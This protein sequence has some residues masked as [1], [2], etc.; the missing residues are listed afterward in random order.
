M[1][2]RPA[3]GGTHVGRGAASALAIIGVASVA[4]IAPSAALAKAQP[5]A[6]YAEFSHCPVYVKKVSACIVAQTTSGEFKLGKKTV[7]ITKT[8]TLQGGLKEGSAELIAPVGAEILSKVPIEVPG[9]L[10]GL[11]G[12]GLGGTTEVNATTELA[13]PVEV[14]QGNL[15][16]G[17]G[18]A[19]T[20]PV[21]VKLE[22]S[23]L[24]TECYVDSATEPIVMNLTTGTTKPPSGVTPITGSSGTINL[25]PTTS[26]ATLTGQS[27]VENDFAVPGASGCG[28]SLS[29]LVDE[30]VDVQV[31]LPAAAGESVAKLDGSSAL[32]PAKAVKKAKVVPKS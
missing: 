8:L 29:A 26:I 3:D 1:R 19:V 30:A 16:E 31:G 9:G 25:N 2:F 21:K 5:N 28:G 10:T 4:A 24:G 32:A 22:N 15:L 23:I 18:T 14:Y 7:H 17:K 12:L 13:G 27:L 20:L 11:E 6:E